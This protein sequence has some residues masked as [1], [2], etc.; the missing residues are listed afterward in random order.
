[1]RYYDGQGTPVF[2]Q[3]IGLRLHGREQRIMPRKSFRLTFQDEEGRDTWLRYP[4]FSEAGNRQYRSLILR[5]GGGDARRAMLRDIVAGKIVAQ[6]NSK[7]GVANTKP[8]IL[9]LNGEY[10]GIYYLTERF[11]EGYFEE[12]YRIPAKGLAIVEVPLD[13]GEKRGDVIAASGKAEKSVERYNQLLKQAKNCFGCLGSDEARQYIDLNNLRDYLIFE[14]FFANKDWPI[15]NTKAWRYQSLDNL[16]QNKDLIPELDGR[17][18][19]L[20]FDLDSGLGAGSDSEAEAV[21]QA[22]YDPYDKLVDDRFPFR[23]FFYQPDFQFSYTRRVQQWA[24]KGLDPETLNKIVDQAVTEIEVEMPYHIARWN[25]YTE[26]GKLSVPATMED[27]RENVS[28]LRL[29]LINRSTTFPGLT[30]DFF[31]SQE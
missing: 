10:W 2:Q 4:V 23:N 9:L 14:L 13:G 16:Q 31:K 7:V 26:L 21:N 6:T 28:M 29:F 8:V 24:N 5:N 22:T 20:L 12:K 1:V 11:D 17:F 19:W 25:G 27:W 15:N 3:R 30:E 18:R